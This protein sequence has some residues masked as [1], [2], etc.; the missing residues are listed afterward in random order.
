MTFMTKLSSALCLFLFYFIYQYQRQIFLNFDIF[1][2]PFESLKILRLFYGCILTFDFS[3][4]V[5]K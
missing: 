1:F 4:Y 5:T 2:G 3:D